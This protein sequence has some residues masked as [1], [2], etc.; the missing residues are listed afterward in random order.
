MDQPLTTTDKVLIGFVIFATLCLAYAVHNDRK[1]SKSVRELHA[2]YNMPDY[3]NNVLTQ[4]N[5]D[6]LRVL[7]KRLSD[8]YRKPYSLND[9]I[10]I[11]TITTNDSL[12][13]L[14]PHVTGEDEK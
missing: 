7:A 12:R 9:T 2:L 8:Y 6:G 11:A 3:G 14:P 13:N 10:L 4:Q 5:I 1:R